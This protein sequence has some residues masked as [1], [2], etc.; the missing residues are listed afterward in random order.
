MSRGRFILSST[1]VVDF[2]R[3]AWCQ[4]DVVLCLF[5]V[6]HFCCDRYL[7]YRLSVLM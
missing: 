5:A 3:F 1:S 6:E 7:F 4:F 2:I